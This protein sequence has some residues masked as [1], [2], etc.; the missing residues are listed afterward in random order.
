ME[1]D[2]ISYCDK[3]LPYFAH[4]KG[5]VHLCVE[6]SDITD[7]GLA[8]A[9]QFPNLEKISAFECQVEGRCLKQLC[10]NKRLR[11]IDMSCC[12]LKQEYFKYL[13]SLPQLQYMN[14]SHSLTTDAGV[15]I[16]ANCKG[17]LV[18]NLSDND[19]V[20]DQCIDQILQLKNLHHLALN[21]TA[22]TFKGALRL[23]SLPL[24]GLSLPGNMTHAQSQQIINAFPGVVVVFRSRRPGP[25][26]SETGKLFAPLH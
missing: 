17:L 21:G 9:C 14:L 13:P 23:K 11:S 1:D 18:L 3:E 20:T 8:A 16:L 10:G 5:V 15:K 2:T 25:V 26:D 7:V 4:Q 12:N 24:E 19:K 6:R 22:V